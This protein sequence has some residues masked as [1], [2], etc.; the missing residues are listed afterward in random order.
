MLLAD[1]FAFA[2]DAFPP[3]PHSSSPDEVKVKDEELGGDLRQTT[4]ESASSS[5]IHGAMSIA[6]DCPESLPQWIRSHSKS[7]RIAADLRFVLR[8]G[9]VVQAGPVEHTLDVTLPRDG[10]E[11]R[12]TIPAEYPFCAPKVAALPV[13]GRAPLLKWV[14]VPHVALLDYLTY[15]STGDE[16]NCEFGRLQRGARAR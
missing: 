7:A 8:E 2:L 4:E 3:R 1:R 11:W 16:P 15:W 13:T 10:G 12:V 9:G 5:L 14:W 6:L